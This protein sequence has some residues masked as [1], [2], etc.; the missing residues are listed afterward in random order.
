MQILAGVLNLIGLVAGVVALCLL[1]YIL[2][3]A[4]P[5]HTPGWMTVL[6]RSYKPHIIAYYV[7]LAVAAAALVLAWNI[8]KYPA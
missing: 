2:P 3:H 5:F 6:M 8:G 4:F 1:V 7:L